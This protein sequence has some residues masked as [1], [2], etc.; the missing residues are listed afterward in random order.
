LSRIGQSYG[1]C[2]LRTEQQ[3]NVRFYEKLGF[4]C[5]ERLE[6]PTTGLPAWFFVREL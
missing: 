4:H 2:A 3:R 5:V 6:V 1:I